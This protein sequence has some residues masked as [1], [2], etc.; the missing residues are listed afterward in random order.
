MKLR[1]RTLNK[2]HCSSLS[3]AMHWPHIGLYIAIS[4]PLG[5]DHSFTTY[6][7]TPILS[8]QPLQ[9]LTISIINQ[10]PN[11][12][13]CSVPLR[14]I[15]GSWSHRGLLVL[16]SKTRTCVLTAA[17]FVG[18]RSQRGIL[19]SIPHYATSKEIAEFRSLLKNLE[20]KTKDSSLK[21]CGFHLY[22]LLLLC[23]KLRVL[24]FLCKYNVFALPHCPI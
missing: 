4:P 15:H 22:S 19:T 7:Y 17:K 1:T 18:N 21:R 6:Q 23:S 8:T 24:S 3:R 16:A 9:A 20:T 13:P 12:F 11:L 2:K 14:N 5:H 10:G